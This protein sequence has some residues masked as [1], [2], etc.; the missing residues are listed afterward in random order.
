[1]NGETLKPYYTIHV[2]WTP[3]GCHFV[4]PH[5]KDGTVQGP[6]S[7]LFPHDGGSRPL[8]KG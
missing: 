5:G 3:V 1:M 4:A 6:V 7:R 8:G 2:P